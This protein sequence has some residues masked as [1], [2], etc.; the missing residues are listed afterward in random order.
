MRLQY[1]SYTF[2]ICNPFS[3]PTLRV[4]ILLFVLIGGWVSSTY[5]QKRYYRGNTHTHSYPGSSGDITDTSYTGTK[6]KSQY[7]AK[8]YDFLVFTDHGAWWNAKVL[9]TPDFTVIN[10]SEP[11][12]SGNGNWGHFTGVN[13]KARVSGANLT[14][15]Q[16]ID[17]IKA[18]SAVPFIN[19]PRYA[20]IPIT[21]FQIINSMKTNLNHMEIWNGVTAGQAGL[22]DIS[23]WDSVLSTGRKFFGVASDDS[24]K[25]TH[26]GKGWIMVYASSINEDTLTKAIREGDF[27]SSNGIFLDSVYYSPSKLYVKS[28]NGEKIQ[29]IGNKGAVLGTVNAS[30]AEY[31]ITGNETYVRA[32]V[33]NAAG[34]KAWTQPIMVS[35]VGIRDERSVQG[36]TFELLQNYPNPFNPEATISYQISAFSSQQSMAGGGQSGMQRVTVRV[37]NLLGK[38]VAELVNEEQGAGQYTVKWNAA[39][40]SSGIYF[41]ELRAGNNRSAIKMLLLK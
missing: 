26:Q 21:A 35:E 12:I 18:Q 6:I 32:E 22:T 37:Y 39:G 10:G 4:V 40:F 5:S 34:K 20:Q 15:Q 8:G 29:F 11:G 14:H 7:T 31:L 24:H 41:C 3:L 38:Q 2:V 16:M 1:D 27:Y 13:M 36:R 33:S 19:H 17:A 28:S 30:T 9:S 23:V 25:E